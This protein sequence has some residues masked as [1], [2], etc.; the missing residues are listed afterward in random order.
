MR[1][2]NILKALESEMPF[3]LS[4]EKK[5][6]LLLNILTRLDQHHRDRC[7]FY[8][9]IVSS[10][11]FSKYAGSLEQLPYIPVRI[12]KHLEMLSVSRENVFKTLLSSGTS[13]TKPS[14][15]FLDRENAANQTK[16]LGATIAHL[17][18]RERIPLLIIDNEDVLKNRETFNARTAATLGF[19]L[20]GK[21]IQ[22][23]LDSKMQ[24][25]ID[26][27]VSFINKH[28]EAKKIA[29]FG[30]THIV[31]QSLVDA[32][33][34]IGDDLKFPEGTLL[35]HGGGWKKMHD[36]QVDNSTFKKTIR[37]RTGISQIH[38]YY[39]MVEQT[40]SI[41]I[42]C[43]SGHLHTSNYCHVIIRDI[44]THR[45]LAFNEQGIIQVQ[46]VLPTSYPGHSLLTEDLGAVHGEDDCPCGR[47][48]RYFSVY[49]RMQES[50]ARGCSDVRT[51]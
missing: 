3:S 11:E 38:N 5:E 34:H 22:Y 31:W 21:N 44:K 47:K 9:A 1:S 48:G 46:S 51:F 40:G 42:E 23:A 25:N 33:D 4:R 29:V 17:L 50:E 43:D 20:H 28:A 39:G 32:L 49:G 27:I 35:L 8:D 12:F 41:F 15:I 7:G 18:G 6:A 19:S 16:V 36:R 24:L 37:E 2:E 13:G 45:P 26:T 10:G 14:R 30:F